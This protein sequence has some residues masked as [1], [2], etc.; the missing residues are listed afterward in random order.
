MN[1]LD[2]VNDI[3]LAIV[4]LLI[5]GD[6]EKLKY[7]AEYLGK[8]K[9]R[10]SLE[11]VVEFVS[12]NNVGYLLYNL[13]NEVCHENTELGI[14]LKPLAIHTLKKTRY[15]NELLRNV[16]KVFETEGIDYVVF[17]TFNSIGVVDVDIDVIIRP[18]DY[19]RGVLALIKGG[20]IPIDSISKTYETGFMIKRNPIVLDLHTDVTVLGVPYV[21]RDLIFE[22]TTKQRYKTCGN[23]VIY[24]NVTSPPIEALIRIAHAVIKEAQICLDDLVEVHKALRHSLADI[25]ELVKLESLEPAFNTFLAVLNKVSDIK[26]LN[27][28]NNILRSSFAKKQTFN[29]LR[30]ELPPYYLPRLVTTLILIHRLRERRELYRAFKAITHLRY[31]RSASHIGRT[32][33]TRIPMLIKH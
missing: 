23:E 15:R 29:Y 10:N 20:L 24:L 6:E 2:S 33:I 11:R 27:S 14:L 28:L 19:E 4:S 13:L 8:V 31:R 3:L 21:S 5:R 30:N 18:E 12:R 22:N 9:D 7:L 32:L 1:N 25:M 17:K 26:C 16:V